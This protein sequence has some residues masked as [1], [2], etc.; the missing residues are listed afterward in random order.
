MAQQIPTLLKYLVQ[1]PTMGA[2]AGALPLGLA[3]P[4]GLK[5]DEQIG[6]LAKGA[7]GKDFGAV[8]LNAP[9]AGPI[10]SAP[11]AAA[12]APATTAPLLGSGGNTPGG[13]LS[14]GSFD[15]PAASSQTGQSAVQQALQQATADPYG[16]GFN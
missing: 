13:G 11:K 14:P 4:G 1:Y 3:V 8:G 16:A 2:V 10:P 9:G 6:D 12:P 5:A 15:P 7:A